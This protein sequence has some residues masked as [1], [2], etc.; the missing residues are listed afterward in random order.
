MARA[1]FM[2][3][4]RSLP[5][6][7]ALAAGLLAL[8]GCATTPGA[9]RLAERDPL[10]KANRVLW[11]VNTTADRLVIKPVTK[12]YRAVAPRPVRQVVTNFFANLAE[13]WSFINNVLQGKPKRAAQNLGRFVVNSTLGIGGLLDPA[14]DMGIPDNEEDLG[15]TL[16]VYG[17]NGG[18]YLMLPFL[19]PSTLRDGI[20]SGVAFYADPINI[21]IKNLDISVWYKRGYRALYILD[22]R[23]D[24]I[25]SGGDAFLE[26]SLDPYAATR[27]AYL[28]RRQAA[29]R[30][31]ENSLDAGPP[32][33]PAADVSDA[34]AGPPDPPAATDAAATPAPATA[35]P[36]PGADATVKTPEQAAGTP[37]P[38]P[39]TPPH[40]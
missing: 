16:A 13:P 39:V 8:A 3:R 36:P 32:D 22:A 33:D 25:E 35:P 23:S 24:L 34:A 21:G 11:G 9:Y 40:P 10:E 29:I 38:E 26:T 1:S 20:G 30:D 2:N 7:T 27:S 19:G 12:G 31:Q 6:R 5:A 37:A 28:Q 17:V 14:T 18:P 15:Q 4:L